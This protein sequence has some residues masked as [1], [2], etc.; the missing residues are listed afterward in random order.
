[1]NIATMPAPPLSALRPT[2]AELLERLGDVPPSRI[3][4]QPPL[5]T[6]TEQDLIEAVDRDGYLCELVD[7][8]L[9]EKPVG[10]YESRLAVVLVSLLEAFQDA[11]DLGIVLGE[12]G[13][14]R[15]APGLVRIPDVAFYGWAQFNGRLLPRGPILVRTPDLAVEIISPSNTEAEMDR[16]RGEY[17]TGGARLVWQVYP[18]TRRVRVYTAVDQFDEIG[19]DETL[20][21]GTVLPGFTLSVRRWFERAGRREE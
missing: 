3:W 18:D 21:G 16:K 13:L 20:T 1:M 8:V 11:S 4:L 9:V 12:G 19:E 17:F 2:L 5:G 6:A 7:G 15:P 10:F 14:M